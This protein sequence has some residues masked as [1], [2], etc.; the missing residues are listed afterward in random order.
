MRCRSSSSRSNGSAMS[1]TM[2][3]ANEI[4]VRR[5]VVYAT[6]DGMQLAGDLYLPKGSGPFPA[7]VAVHGGGWRLGARSSFQ[8][9]GP[10]LAARGYALY[11]ISYRLAAKGRKTY[12]Q[13][14]NDVCAAVQFVRGEAKGFNIDGGRIALMGASAG[15]HPSSMGGPAGGALFKGHPGGQ[16]ASGGPRGQGPGGGFWVYE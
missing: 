14:V 4:E 3:D 11:A 1:K 15:A 16:H 6:H 10:H 7:L 2:S 13:A 8:Y 5:D 12:P 9:W